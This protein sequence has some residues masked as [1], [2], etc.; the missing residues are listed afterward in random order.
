LKNAWLN[1]ALPLCKVEA[2]QLG[3]DRFTHMPKS[4][5]DPRQFW[6]KIGAALCV[7]VFIF[8]TATWAQ[9]EHRLPALG[10]TVSENF[11]V[12]TERRLGEHIM[13]EIWRDPDYLDDPVVTD[14]LQSIWQPLLNAAKARGDIGPEIEQRFAWETFGVRD[15]SVNAFA[16]PGG[17]VGVHLGL[18]AMT[19]T[20]DE[21]ASVLGHEMSHITQRHIG[22][23]IANSKK[24]SL[25]GAAAMIIGVLAATRSNRTDGAN[26]VM[27]S[28][29]AL[30]IQGQLNF[31]RDMEREADRIGFGVMSSAGFAPGGMA[32]MFE[33]LEHNARLNDSGGFPYLRSHPL[34]SE[35]IGEAR[36]RLGFAPPT[37]PASTLAHA[38]ARA[39]AR[40]LMDTRAVSLRHW[41]N[42][43][44][45]K[46]A[47]IDDQ[48]MA[49][50]ANTLASTLLRDWARAE[51][52]WQQATRLAQDNLEAKRNTALLGAE[53]ALARGQ[54]PR[55]F[56]LLA[57][58]ADTSEPPR[59]V[60]LL[61][62]QAS[63]VGGDTSLKKSAEQLQ[64]LVLQSPQDSL[65]WLALS[66][67]WRALNY[68]LRALRA[69]AESKVAMG[70]FSAALDR[71]RE[72]QRQAR[73]AAGKADAI[74]VSVIESRLRWID[75][76]RRK[77]V[78]EKNDF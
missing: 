20:P 50:Y 2:L 62:A 78:Q 8:P 18:L 59:A 55:A 17:Y 34:T 43:T 69:E 16:L 11:D 63:L 27:A 28:G 67:V 56:E 40:V 7:S 58:Y 29:Q 5:H 41:Q 54:A 10:D 9:P 44:P 61:H 57:P 64:A 30:A 47:T 32:A 66:Q 45:E 77:Q 4:K 39:R 37:L 53:L 60:V 19:T 23:S 21:L 14:Y 70:D 1:G 49:A 25:L 35:R 36:S 68:P 13:R 51:T 75:A 76:Q 52:A 65:A 12:G 22:R 42:L 15:R 48:L 74:E 72:G 33:K 26:A 31:S 46:N 24:Q 38:V 73:A 3:F 71:L 6:K